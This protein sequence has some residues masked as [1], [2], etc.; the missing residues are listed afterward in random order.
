MW[1]EAMEVLEM[2]LVAVSVPIQVEKMV[3]HRGHKSEKYE[4][5]SAMTSHENTCQGQTH[6]RIHQSWRNS[7]QVVVASSDGKVHTRFDGSVDG[8]IQRHGLA[9]SQRHVGD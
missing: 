5:L 2:V 8:I 3:K 1:G 4:K 6:Q 7:L 9:T